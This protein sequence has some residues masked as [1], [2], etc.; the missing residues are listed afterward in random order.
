MI[1]FTLCIPTMDRYNKFLSKNLP[2]YLENPYITEIIITDE[3]GND[4]QNIKNNLT[5]PDKRKLF[6]NEKN[7]GPF[8]NKINACSKATNKWIALIDS[9]N[10][11]DLNYFK[12]ASNYIENTE[13]SNNT[14]IS[15][16]GANPRFIFNHLSNN[17]INKNNLKT[18]KQDKMF[19]LLMNT[20]NFVLNKY[21]IENLKLE[22]NVNYEHT[23][24]SDVM[25]FNTLCFEQLDLNFYV[26][27]DLEYNHVKHCESIYRQTINVPEVN[28]FEQYITERFFN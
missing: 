1:Y 4:I 23:S 18:I 2:N 17:I 24:A 6:K 22:E 15:P 27:K 7:L 21:I 8:L 25:Y 28:K 20:G 10:F 5:I 16:C 19:L 14:I 26:V 9:D 3:N 11:A 13:L 12:I